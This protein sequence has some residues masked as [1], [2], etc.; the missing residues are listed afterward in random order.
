[1]VHGTKENRLPMKTT[2]TGHAPKARIVIAGPL[3]PPYGGQNIN[4]A[5]MLQLLGGYDEFEV[6]RLRVEFSK[7]VRS[8]R[9]GGL[10]RYHRNFLG[11]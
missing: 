2:R 6:L 3:P 10:H 5:R 9:Q 1:M 11:F 8:F 7:G 4:T